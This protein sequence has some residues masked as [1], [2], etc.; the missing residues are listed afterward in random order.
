MWGSVVIFSHTFPHTVQYHIFKSLLFQSEKF[1]KSKDFFFL[2]DLKYGHNSLSLTCY[3][4]NILI[5]CM[6]EIKPVSLEG[7]QHWIFIGRTMTEAE[8]PILWLP[9]AKSWLTGKDPD[10]GKDWRQKRRG[11]QRMS[12]LDSITDSVDRI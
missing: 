4:K 1:E 3:A 11:W 8:A 6:L 12:W 2:I 5:F 9:A 7:N 10:A